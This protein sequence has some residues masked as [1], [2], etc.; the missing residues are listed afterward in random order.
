MTVRTHMVRLRTA[1]LVKNTE[2]CYRLAWGVADRDCAR[3]LAE[4]GQQYAA[5]AIERGADPTSL[6]G[7]EEW[8]RIA[9]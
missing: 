5:Q 1:D 9:N 2:R 8:R 3:Q 7:P 6:P 4:M